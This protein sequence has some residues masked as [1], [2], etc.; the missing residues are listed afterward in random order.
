MAFEN[1]NVLYIL[2][3]WNSTRRIQTSNYRE[4]RFAYRL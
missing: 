2:F 4:I 3:R 1:L